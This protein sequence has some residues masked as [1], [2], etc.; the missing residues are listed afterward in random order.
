MEGATAV[1]NQGVSLRSRS[2]S[3]LV[4]FWS[5]PAIDPPPPPPTGADERV[6]VRGGSLRQKVKKGGFTPPPLN[7]AGERVCVRKKALYNKKIRKGGKKSKVAS[8]PPPPS[9]LVAAMR[10]YVIKKNK[11]KSTPPPVAAVSAYVFGKRLCIIK[12]N[13]KR[14][15]S[16][17]RPLISKNI[18]KPAEE[19][20]NGI[21][22]TLAAAGSPA[23]RL[24]N[25][26][27]AGAVLENLF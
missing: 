15:D 14:R 22:G 10:L 9:P 8:L 20:K 27:A 12:K 21:S 6:C 16:I 1:V 4:I 19:R 2:R 23:Y 25:W 13:P 24:D 7:G 18:K 17:P 3:C 11:K 26:F 5:Q